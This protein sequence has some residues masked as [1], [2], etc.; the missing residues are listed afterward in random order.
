MKKTIFFFFFLLSILGYSKFEDIKPGIYENNDNAYNGGTYY[1]MREKWDNVGF[2]G[3]IIVYEGYYRPDGADEIAMAGSSYRV[4][5]CKE[6]KNGV[7]KCYSDFFAIDN[8]RMQYLPDG[9]VYIIK[10]NTLQTLDH[11]LVYKFSRELKKSD[12]KEAMKIFSKAP[13]N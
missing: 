9:E 12:R 13:I 11:H 3:I 4:S 6:S 8:E 10:D 2:D 7:L 5:L 1:V